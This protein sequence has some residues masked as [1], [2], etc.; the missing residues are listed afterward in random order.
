[1]KIPRQAKLYECIIALYGLSVGIHSLLTGTLPSWHVTLFFVAAGI[2]FLQITVQLPSGAIYSPSLPII[3]A[4]LLM[5]GLPLA[6]LILILGCM[7]I[8]YRKGE[9][10]SSI[11]FSGG[12]VTASAQVALF[13]YETSRNLAWLGAEDVVAVIV[14][15]MAFDLA[16]VAL[17]VGQGALLRRV[18]AWKLYQQ[19]LFRDRSVLVIPYHLLTLLTCLLYMDRGFLGLT[20]G[21]LCVLAIKMLLVFQT[22]LAETNEQARLDHLTGTYNYRFLSEWFATHA[23]EMEKKRRALSVFFIDMDHL[24]E[25]NDQHGH[26]Q[27]DR[28]IMHLADILRHS[29]RSTDLLC[30][31]GGD[32]FVIVCPDM[33]GK[34]AGDVSARIRSIAQDTPF[35]AGDQS[36]PLR[37]SLGIASYPEDN[38]KVNLDLIRQADQ[39]MYREKHR[40][41]S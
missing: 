7:I 37:F 33:D 22:N 8:R 5:H 14:A 4:A 18:S 2:G 31:Y 27:G 13:I 40:S 28:A 19:C 41:P 11:L 1:M 23:S 35:Q 16:N 30:R 10:W 6:A 38:G 3:M 15:T 34:T 39:V 24:K 36:F 25:I 29:I 21:L 9:R 12:M 17:G 32:E 26:P 20:T